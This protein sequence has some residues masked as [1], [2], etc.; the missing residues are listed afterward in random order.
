MDFSVISEIILEGKKVKNIKHF[1]PSSFSYLAPNWVVGV[2]DDN[3]LMH[4]SLSVAR[5]DNSC[6]ILNKIYFCSL[7]K[8]G[9]LKLILEGVKST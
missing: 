3:S 1:V 9:I 6:L 2:R 7:I 4:S 5:K 8:P